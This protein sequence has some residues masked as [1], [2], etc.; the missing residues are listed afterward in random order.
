MQRKSVNVYFYVMILFMNWV[1]N[2]FL[3][4][5]DIYCNFNGLLPRN[6]KRI[7]IFTKKTHNFKHFSLKFLYEFNNTLTQ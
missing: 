2:N 4:G 1:H 3:T 5:G 6:I 7:S